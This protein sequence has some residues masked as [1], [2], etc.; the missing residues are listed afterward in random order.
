[1][2]GAV[3]FVI[4][5]YINALVKEAGAPEFQVGMYSAAAEAL[6]MLFECVTAPLTARLSDIWGRKPVLLVGVFLFATLGVVFGCTH[7]L[8]W[9]LTIRCIQGAAAGVGSVLTRTILGELTDKTN[10][11]RGEHASRTWHPFSPHS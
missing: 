1:M 3:W 7:H 4:V 11:V 2:S 9:I 10:I 5:P 8:F 6:F